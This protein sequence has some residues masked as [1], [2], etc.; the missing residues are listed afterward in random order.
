MVKSN[1]FGVEETTTIGVRYFP[2]S[3]TV[4]PRTMETVNSRYGE[5]AV[6]AVTLPSG[7]VRRTPEYED[8]RRRAVEVG[9]PVRD[10]MGEALRMCIEADTSG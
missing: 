1:S 7:R 8:C 5:I 9:V 3:R 10:V 2:V 6:K 4:L